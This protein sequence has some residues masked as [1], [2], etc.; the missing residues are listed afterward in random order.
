MVIKCLVL[1]MYKDL[2]EKFLGFV[3]VCSNVWLCLCRSFCFTFITV[4]LGG[5]SFMNP[6]PCTNQSFKEIVACIPALL[7]TNIG[8][9]CEI[10]RVNCLK[11]GNFTPAK[12][13]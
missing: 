5:N 3:I 2:I 12:G 10:K 9:V 8:V 7:Y 13:F 1:N 6:L 11:G 4:F